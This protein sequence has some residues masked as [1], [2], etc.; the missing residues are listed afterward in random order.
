MAC[1]P[2]AGCAAEPQEACVAEG[3]DWVQFPDAPCAAAA[4]PSCVCP[5][6]RLGVEGSALPQLLGGEN[7]RFD[8]EEEALNVALVLSSVLFVATLPLWPLVLHHVVGLPRA[9]AVPTGGLLKGLLRRSV[10]VQ[11]GALVGSMLACNWALPRM[12]PLPLE[13]S[14]R[15]CVYHQMFCEA[16]VHGE[17]LVRHPANTWSNVGFIGVACLVLQRCWA[18]R[19]YR[20]FDGAFGAALLALALCSTAWHG[21][22]CDTAH[23]YDLALMNAVLLFFPLRYL[24]LLL[25]SPAYAL[26]AWLLILLK[27]LRTAVIYHGAG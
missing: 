8:S 26:A 13:C 17:H 23:Y 22:N 3:C 15:V 4:A 12:L 11:G 25:P 1:A 5:A 6:A 24:S 7:A 16:T 14:A 21:T 18:A 20:V 9:E 27:E 19:A 10:A 2:I